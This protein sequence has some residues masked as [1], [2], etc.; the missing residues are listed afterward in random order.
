MR[1]DVVLEHRPSGR[2][3][4]ID[5][6]FNSILTRGWYREETLRS[7]YLYRIYA[8][9]RSQAGQGD[10]I[11]DRA[12]GVLLHPAVGRNIDETAV[13]QGHAI[14]FATV[15]L[16]AESATIRRQLLKAAAPPF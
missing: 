9:I 13:V 7:G 8:C 2:R 5:T 14:R 16:A 15:D 10:P 1:T 11:A 6:K 12:E 4:A 3:I